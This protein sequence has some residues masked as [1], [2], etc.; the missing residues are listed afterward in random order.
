MFVQRE[1]DRLNCH[2]MQT[3]STISEVPTQPQAGRK[4]CNGTEWFGDWVKL[5]NGKGKLFNFISPA[6]K[7]ITCNWCKLSRAYVEKQK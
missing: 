7:D 2:C 3:L 6:K 1:L 5:F 4:Y